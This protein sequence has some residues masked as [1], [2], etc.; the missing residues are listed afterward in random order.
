MPRPE[1]IAAQMPTPEAPGSTLQ[2]SALE[3]KVL[4]EAIDTAFTQWYEGEPQ[5][6]ADNVGV[7]SDT[8]INALTA[9]QERL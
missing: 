4:A 3:R 1:E 2:L 9:I 7:D 8:L 6:A 5:I